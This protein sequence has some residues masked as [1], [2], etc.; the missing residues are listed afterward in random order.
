[1]MSAVKGLS[2]ESAKAEAQK[3]L[4]FFEEIGLA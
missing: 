1:M 4:E 3:E 2:D